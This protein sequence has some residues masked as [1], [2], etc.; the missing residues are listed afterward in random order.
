[1]SITDLKGLIR[2]ELILDEAGLEARSSDFGRMVHRRPGA[3]V[4]PVDAADVA[5]VIQFANER[6]I[7]VSSRGEAHTQTGQ[8]LNDGGIVL[9][10]TSLN[11]IERL[12]AEAGTVTCGAGTVWRNLVE[13]LKPHGFIP[14]VLTNNLG[15]TI[16]GT[17]S[18][19]GLG[20]ASFRYGTQADN[21]VELEVVTGAGQVVVCSAERNAELF[22]HVRSS[23]GQIGVI[24]KAMIKVRRFQPMVRRFFVL[25]DD[26]DKFMADAK[27]LMAED[28]C[29]FLEAWCVPAP[30]GFRTVG[31]EKQTFGEWFFPMHITV[32]FDPASPPDN[33]AV[34]RG[35]SFYRNS[36]VEDEPIHD[37]AL[38]LEPLFAL[39]KLSG[40]WA[41]MHPW[42]ETILPWEGGAEYIKNVLAVLPPA[43]LGGG[44]ILL[45]PCRVTT[46]HVPLFMKPP[47]DWVVG[48]GILPGIPRERIQLAVERLDMASQFSEMA[49]G[50]RYLSG[51]IHFDHAGWKN[52]FGPMWPVL[53]RLKKQYDPKGVLNPGFIQ[54]DE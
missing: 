41:N 24:T 47:D 7:K 18:V 4:R 45:W 12:D 23:L 16:G 1:M 52:H 22:N 25:Y 27:T 49:G 21:A 19:A 48:F 46:S 8:S 51:M 34:L 44:H 42:M 32:E 31:T 36:H 30:M 14:R 17:L 13:H 28:R 2:G 50:K 26:L 40:Y 15:V 5:T 3:V 20:V 11:Q 9:D 33:D 39:W 37:F 54:Y 38:R 35:L 43:S 29:D 53:N 10:L 6:G